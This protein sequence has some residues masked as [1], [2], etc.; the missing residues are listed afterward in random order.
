MRLRPVLLLACLLL[1]ALGAWWLLSRDEARPAASAV[2]SAPAPTPPQA[3]FTAAGAASTTEPLPAV[4]APR[5]HAPGAPAAAT[6]VVPDDSSDISGVVRLVSGELAGPGIHVAA[7]PT[8]EAP[9]ETDVRGAMEVPVGSV[10]S[11]PRPPLVFAQTDESS[12][13]RISGLIAGQI[14]TVCAAARGMYT[15]NDGMPWKVMPGTT[16]L[17]VA[18]ARVY[19]VRVLVRGEDGELPLSNPALWSRGITVPPPPQQLLSITSPLIPLIG[20]DGVESLPRGRDDV[21]LLCLVGADEPGPLSVGGRVAGYESFH[22]DVPLTPVSAGLP[23]VEIRLRRICE[24]FARVTIEVLGAGPRLEPSAAPTGG[25][26]S[27]AWVELTPIDQRK[28]M[29]FELTLDRMPWQ[30]VTFD[31]IPVGRYFVRLWTPHR[32]LSVPFED[33]PM[34]EVEILPGDNLLSFDVGTVGA[35]ELLPRRADGRPLLGPVNV[36]LGSESW[37]R[38]IQQS[39]SFNQP[40]YVLEGLPVGRYRVS[41]TYPFEAACDADADGYFRVDGSRLQSIAVQQAA[42]AAPAR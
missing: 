8:D 30:G 26:S 18:V 25:R 41:I 9:S 33:Q 14:Y 3:K 40:P 4:S 1:A 19:G 6:P 42:G 20:L 31:N 24:A 37:G 35:I 29:G 12:A 27:H 13:F 23:T 16:D 10:T 38:G 32:F 36:E 11:N 22:R 39:A 34:R 2:L 7:W 5:A 17:A 28:S 21:V 15:P